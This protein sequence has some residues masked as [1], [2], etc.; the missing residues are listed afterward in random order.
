[1]AYIKSEKYE[2][3]F[4][5][6]KEYAIKDGFTKEELEKIDLSKISKKTKSPRIYRFILWSYYLSWLKGIQFCDEMFNS[7]IT[8][9]NIGKPKNSLLKIINDNYDSNQVKLFIYIMDNID[10]LITFYDKDIQ[11]NIFIYNK[12]DKIYIREFVQNNNQKGLLKY[13]S[14]IDCEWYQNGKLIK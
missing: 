4:N 9:R 7:K 10:Y 14:N 8:F 1:M 12:K 6:I 11:H 5:R 3:L 2:K 13:I